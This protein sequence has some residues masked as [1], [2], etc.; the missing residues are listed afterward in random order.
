MMPGT[1]RSL[2]DGLYGDPEIAALFAPEAEIRAMVTVEVALAEA[3]DRLGM[4]QPD[5]G[6]AVRKAA[7]SF[8]P[9]TDA[10]TD[11]TRRS[12]VPVPALV[13]ALRTHVGPPHGEAVHR[14]ATSQDIVDTALVLRLRTVLS[15]LEARL[16]ALAE[17]LGEAASR[18]AALLMA[19]RTR[20]Q[21]AVPTTLGLRVAGWLAPLQRCRA[22]LAELRPRLLTVQLGGAAGTLGAFG[23]RG[24]A[25]MEELAAALDLAAPAKPWHSERDTL[26]EAAQWLA[27]VTGALGKMGGDLILM[28]RSENAEMRAG[29]GGGSSTM[30]HKSNPVAAEA[31]VALARFNAGQVGTAHQALLHAE[32]RDGAAWG[33]EWLILPQMAVATGAALGH[34]LDLARSI[35]PDAARMR[36]ALDD[37]AMAEAAAFAL[38]AHRPLAGAQSHVRRAIRDGTP[39]ADALREAGFDEAE[40]AAALDPARS[41]EMAA[42]LIARVVASFDATGK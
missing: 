11:G 36:A 24:I 37:G 29:Q 13:A 28:G 25:V 23:S 7:E 42:P 20:S 21:V 40:I 16:A 22:R 2:L 27:L 12:G 26:V 41:L 10:L 17:T 35:E 19:A 14:G 8:V 1:G 4:V 34:A 33:L 15:I 5:A 3:M 30:P 6:E 38:A 39:L 9:D 31:V 32:E 18:H